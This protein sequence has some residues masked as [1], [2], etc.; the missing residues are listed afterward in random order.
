[1]WQPQP[2]ARRQSNVRKA[3]ARVVRQFSRRPRSCVAFPTSPFSAYVPQA[4]QGDR[5]IGE[6]SSGMKNATKLV[7]ETCFLGGAGHRSAVLTIA[8][9]NK[10]GIRLLTSEWTTSSVR[11][12]RAEDKFP[13]GQAPP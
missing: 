2:L 6:G 1:M 13:R 10:T 7:I 5:R 11:A 3:L 4:G 8:R 9:C 12:V